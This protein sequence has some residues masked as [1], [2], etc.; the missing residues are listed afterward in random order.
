MIN[1]CRS[2]G[3]ATDIIAVGFNPRINATHTTPAV[4][5]VD[6]NTEISTPLNG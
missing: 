5:D 6:W 4:E 2:P 3:G 1:G